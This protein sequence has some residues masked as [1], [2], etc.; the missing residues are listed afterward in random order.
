[1]PVMSRSNA[2]K[3]VEKTGMILVFPLPNKKDP[4]SLWS[5]F[6][7]RTKMRWEWD[8]S[9]DNRV[10]ELWHLRTEL[11]SSGKLVY[12]KWFQGRATLF[13]KPLFT[14]MMRYLQT[15]T[16]TVKPLSR[17]AVAILEFLNEDSPQSPRVVRE[18]VNL[19]GKFHES[20]FQRALKELWTRLLIVG[21]GEIDDGAF[22]SLAIGST[23]LLFED[24]WL[25]S[26][27]LTSEESLTCIELY[28]PQESAARKYLTRMERNLA[29]LDT[30][31]NKK[32]A[33]TSMHIPRSEWEQ[34]SSSVRE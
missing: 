15:A 1:M 20:T 25:A 24:E 4:S 16:G 19:Q 30:K 29:K 27:D 7:P 22:P 8:E 34:R 23:K 5:H 21:Y 31:N 2:I 26:Q 33:P 18:A 32:S 12:T 9:G 11:S 6:F 13:S 14:A 28:M 10:A 3:A 17:E